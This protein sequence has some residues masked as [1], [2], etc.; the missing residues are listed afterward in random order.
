LLTSNEKTF[1]AVLFTFQ[2][3]PPVADKPMTPHL[4]AIRGIF[5]LRYQGLAVDDYSCGLD[6]LDLRCPR[7]LQRKGPFKSDSGRDCK[8]FKVA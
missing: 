2:E 3:S 8:R 7:L 5:D 6:A 4:P 1:F